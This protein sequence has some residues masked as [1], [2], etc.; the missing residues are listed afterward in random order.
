[1]KWVSEI[2]GIVVC[3]RCWVGGMWSCTTSSCCACW[4]TH[5]WQSQ[6]LR[7]VVK[8]LT[9]GML[10]AAPVFIFAV[11]YLFSHGHF[12]VLVVHQHGVWWSPHWSA[13]VG[14]HLIR[15][16][17]IDCRL[18]KVKLVKRVRDNEMWVI[19]NGVHCKD[20]IQDVA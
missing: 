1:M 11:S 2:F 16:N 7:C 4:A 19:I 8:T 5:S 14:V 17:H 20:E 9:S 15:L 12:P 6:R 13:A 10:S 18:K 3:C